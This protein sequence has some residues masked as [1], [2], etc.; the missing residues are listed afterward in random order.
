MKNFSA[1]LYKNSALYTRNTMRRTGLLA[2]L[3]LSVAS[4]TAASDALA[5]PTG[6]TVQS[7]DIS[8]SQSGNTLNITQTSNKGII[9]WQGF[10]IL[11]GETVNVNQARSSIELERVTSG[12]PTQI[13]GNLNSQGQVW[14]VNGSG[15]FFGKSAKINVGSM[16]ASTANITNKNFNAGHY[17]FDQPGNPNA[18]IINEGHITARKGGLVALVAPGVVNNGVI[19]AKLGTVIL[20]AAKKFTLDLYG[21]GL[22]GFAVNAPATERAND[23]NGNPLGAAIINT[24]KISGGTVYLTADAA[25]EVVDQAI[26][27]TGIIDATGIHKEGGTIVLDGGEGN[28]AVSGTLNASG[29]SGGNITVSGGNIAI[30]NATINASGGTTINSGKGTINNANN[31]LNPPNNWTSPTLNGGGPVINI[32]STPNN[33][34][35][36]TGGT[37]QVLSK[38]GDIKLQA[39]KITATG[40]TGGGTVNIGGGAHGTGNLPHAGS[41][42]MDADSTIDVS[43]TNTGNGGNA[44]L[45]S[46]GTTTFNGKILA[47]GGKNGGN[48]GQVETSG[49]VVK[50]AN[51]FVDASAPK[52]KSGDWLL[53]P[54]DVVITNTPG[55]AAEVSY[56][57][58]GQIE[59]ELNSGTDY[60]IESESAKY[61][62]SG[63]NGGS[64]TVLDNIDKTAGGNA[65][66]TLDAATDLVLG[67]NPTNGNMTNT[68]TTVAGLG[69]PIVPYDEAS[70]NLGITSNSGA[71]NLVLAAGAGGNG[72]QVVINHNTYVNTNGGN[73]SITGTGGNNTNNPENPNGSGVLI[74]MSHINAGGGGISINGNVLN[75]G[76]VA[77]NANGVE[78]IGSFLQTSG[79]GVVSV[80]GTAST[81]HSAAKSIG[82][83]IAF[84]NIESQN[85]AL[86]IT[87]TG[88]NS[89]GLAYG[90]SSFYTDNGALTLNGTTTNGTYGIAPDSTIAGGNNIIS[91][92]G[93]IAYNAGSND[94]YLF[95][96][97]AATTGNLT[98]NANNVT[99][100]TDTSL[101]AGSKAISNVTSTLSANTPFGN[102]PA[103]PSY[104]NTVPS[105]ATGTV[106]INNTGVFYTNNSGILN[107]DTVTLRQNGGNG[108]AVPLIG[109]TRIPT[110]SAT[111]I[112]A[113]YSSINVATNAFGNIG[114]ATLTLGNGTWN[115]AVNLTKSNVTITGQGAGNTIIAP[116]AAVE[117]LATP[118][119]Y[120]KHGKLVTP[121]VFTPI[122][123]GGTGTPVLVRGTND[124]ISNLTINA[125][126]TAIPSGATNVSGL[127]FNGSTGGG[128]NNLQVIGQSGTASDVIQ[129]VNANGTT[130]S[131]GN[132][133]GQGLNTTGIQLTNTQNSTIT[134]V[135]LT[136]DGTGI[137]LSSGSNGNTISNNIINGGTTGITV[138]GTSNNLISANHIDNTAGNAIT[139]SGDTNLTIAGNVIGQAS[140]STIGSTGINATNE[141]GLVI[142][143]NA[144]SHATVGINVL[145]SSGVRFASN[146]I[147][148]NVIGVTLTGSNNASFSGDTISSNDT[149]IDINNSQNANITDA[150]F[151]TNSIGL[152]LENGSRGTSVSSST[153]SDLAIDVLINGGGATA[154]GTSANM[155]FGDNNN[156]FTRSLTGSTD[157]FFLE[158]GGMVGETLDA[159]HQ[160]FGGVAASAFTPG[161][162]ANAENRTVDSHINPSLGHVF[163]GNFGGGPS[164]GPSGAGTFDAALLDQLLQ[165]NT[166]PY[167]GALFSYAGR[168]IGGGVPSGTDIS[169]N[170]SIHDINLS[171]LAPATGV[172]PGGI[173]PVGGTPGQLANLAPAAGGDATYYAS[174][175]PAAGGNNPE[176]C[177]NSFLSDALTGGCGNK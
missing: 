82:T 41:V 16:I 128:T 64:I 77:T 62:G 26:N 15:V 171:M 34:V 42:E 88:T 123:V 119:V 145:N 109:G 49:R 147:S 21:D 43:A 158:N 86:T 120:D 22:Y 139:A 6:G 163:Y 164:G 156:V 17:I 12:S 130:I 50:T 90:G 154:P 165:R 112:Q 1:A 136:N 91:V 110:G 140:G 9:N 79:T 73:V 97:N 155:Q 29:S 151:D 45:W 89:Y 78:I 58:P 96:D 153:F 83:R 170:F 61:T 51:G 74:N 107:G 168:S 117:T 19:K 144:V 66:L 46:D 148:N 69:N 27:T 7:G 85:G 129:L 2:G 35:I 67:G 166:T 127:I 40:A 32:G 59:A 20:G 174:L 149:G 72:G 76:L 33:P 122:V 98:V 93:N 92:G 115:E 125:T 162:F 116:T 81:N 14:I 161:D 124:F 167:P 142:S 114:N 108:V 30:T 84:S 23:Q 57:T 172:A 24:G 138:N 28:V 95:S 68:G 60:T 56:I 63:P 8:M 141:T 31:G 39:A 103:A 150:T 126:N 157:Y 13:L 131:N 106:A 48:G 70:S 11:N 111:P 152:V 25:K 99:M 102:N 80:N 87:G 169:Y 71:L 160:T 94:A 104:G 101:S 121:P 18:S 176:G 53:D 105:T 4:M 37:I 137:N 100:T 159:S 143:G 133:V 175:A 75:N 134:G 3:A 177:V 135:T 5:L 47:K 118:A 10:D 38:G 132:L 52:G 173:P 36:G 44:V 146:T 65:T 55:S 113:P 54:D